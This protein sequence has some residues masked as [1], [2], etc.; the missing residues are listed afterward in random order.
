MI[1]NDRVIAI[2]GRAR[3]VKTPDGHYELRGGTPED[4]SGATEWISLF[5]HEA[6]PM[7]VEPPTP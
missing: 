6:V 3:L 2:F 4:R 5:L 7:E 1:S